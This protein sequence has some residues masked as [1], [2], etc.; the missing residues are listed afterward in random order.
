MGLFVRTSRESIVPLQRFLAAFVVYV[1]H[2]CLI[3]GDLS[4]ILW[5]WLT[6]SAM[7]AMVTRR[8]HPSQ[9]PKRFSRAGPV[10]LLF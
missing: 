10:F 6:Y 7:A 5:M 1:V 4:D 3:E 8:R 2:T 9:K